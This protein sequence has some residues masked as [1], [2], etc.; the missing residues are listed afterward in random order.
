MSGKAKA[1]DSG[2]EDAAAGLV[3]L[4]KPQYLGRILSI[5]DADDLWQ[6]RIALETAAV[7]EAQPERVR[8]LD[9]S[10]SD[11]HLQLA[12]SLDNRYL[13]A[14]LVETI[15]ELNP[16]ESLSRLLLAHVHSTRVHEIL[17]RAMLAGDVG[18]A[19]LMVA[20]H[21]AVEQEVSKQALIQQGWT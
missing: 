1:A 20:E 11:F 5:K 18:L 21:L 2:N 15:G 13:A 17:T 19:R 14:S 6:L 9:A 4:M 3:A 12:G 8:R 16:Y 7:T 10:T